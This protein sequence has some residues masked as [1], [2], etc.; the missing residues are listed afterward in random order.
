MLPLL[1]TVDETDNGECGLLRGQ[2]V[3]PRLSSSAG[4]GIVPATGS[5]QSVDPHVMTDSGAHS[6][7]PSD[8]LILCSFLI[9]EVGSWVE[10]GGLFSIKR[11]EN[12]TCRGDVLS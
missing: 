9:E 8:P 2:V 6:L 10:R 5:E 4:L 11:K 3:S 12:D 1:L 7:F